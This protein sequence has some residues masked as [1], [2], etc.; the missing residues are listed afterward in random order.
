M[1]WLVNKTSIV[2]SD[3]NRKLVCHAAVMSTRLKIGGCC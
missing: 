1:H 2:T 3:G